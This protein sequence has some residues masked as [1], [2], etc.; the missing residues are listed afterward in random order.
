[1]PES[2]VPGTLDLW[3]HIATLLRLFSSPCV[4]DRNVRGFV[5]VR[6]SRAPQQ[7]KITRAPT[8]RPLSSTTYTLDKYHRGK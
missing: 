8:R 6:L 3:N 2:E 1:M 5:S 7:I 4:L